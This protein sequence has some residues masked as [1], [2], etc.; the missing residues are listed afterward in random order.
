MN[1]GGT[2]ARVILYDMRPGG[3]ATGKAAVDEGLQPRPDGTVDRALRLEDGSIIWGSE[4]WWDIP[5]GDTE[6]DAAWVAT[7]GEYLEVVFGNTQTVVEG[8]S[9]E[10][11]AH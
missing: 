1:A 7:F 10:S 11:Q 3:S 2:L 4:C 9:H 6:K 5:S 8:V